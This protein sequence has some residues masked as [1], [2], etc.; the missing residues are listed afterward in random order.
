LSS[1]GTVAYFQKKYSSGIYGY[2][3]PIT[4][5]VAGTAKVSI[6]GVPQ[7]EVGFLTDENGNRLLDESANRIIDNTASSTVITIDVNQGTVYFLPALTSGDIVT[8][9]FEFDVPVRFDTDKLTISIDAFNHGS[10]PAIGI[11]EIRV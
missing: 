7:E 5:L 3:R 6:N 1:D 8:A 11:R 2:I 4:K 9:G 10:V